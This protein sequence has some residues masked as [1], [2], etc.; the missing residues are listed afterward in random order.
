M[1]RVIGLMGCAGVAAVTMAAC[2]PPHPKPATPLKAVTALDCPDSQGDLTR[3]SAS[4]DGKSCDYATSDGDQVTVQLVALNGSDARAALAPIEA[5]LKAEL[6]SVAAEP[7]SP[8]DTPDAPSGPKDKHKVDIDLPGIHIH[9]SGDGHANVDAPGV[10][11]DAHDKDGKTGHDNADVR[12]GAG[13]AGIVV[14]AN[15]S[16]AQVRID[17]SGS[18]IRARYIL[19]SETAGPH[20]Y[21]LAGYEARGPRGGPLVVAILRSKSDDEDTLHD[22]IRDLLKHNVG[23]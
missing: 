6:P 17:E 12:I 11:V 8:P 18:G 1:K 19:A 9:A 13:S 3:K 16:G 7:P 20:G 5:Q 4:A 15:D 2:S 14:N 23:G 21:K 22:D 10:H